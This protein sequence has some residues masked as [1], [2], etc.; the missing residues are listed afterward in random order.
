MPHGGDQMKVYVGRVVSGDP[1]EHD[2]E[3]LEVRWFPLDA[4][5]KRLFKFSRE[6]IEDALTHAG[7]P[8]EK[9]QRFSGVEAGLLACFLAYRRVRN[10]LRRWE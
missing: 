10:R 5:P 1:S 4:L 7:A 6:H 9:E 2:R 3:N 8:V